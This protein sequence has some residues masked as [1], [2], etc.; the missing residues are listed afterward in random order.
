MLGRKW[1]GMD[2]THLSIALQKYRLEAIGIG[3]E[4]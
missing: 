1:I 3:V 4:R 2:I